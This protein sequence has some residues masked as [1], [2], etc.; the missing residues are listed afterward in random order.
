[1]HGAEE[2]GGRAVRRELRAVFMGEKG[3][4]SGRVAPFSYLPAIPIS[5]LDPTT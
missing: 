5:S 1:M 4:N 3:A 2:E